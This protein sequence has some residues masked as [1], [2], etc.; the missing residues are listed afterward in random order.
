MT[1]HLMRA[2]VGATLTFVLAG[3]LCGTF[4]VRI[5]ALAD[6]LDISKTEVGLVLLVW[7]LGAL[8]TMQGMRPIM[9]R[10]GSRQVLRFAAPAC[11]IALIPLAFAPSLTLTL[12]AAALFGMAFGMVDIAMNAQGATVERAAARPAMNGMHAGWCVG[13]IAAGLLGTLA[14]QAGL[15]FTAHLTLIALLGVPASVLLS[16]TYLPDAPVRAEAGTARTGRLPRIVYLLGAI[17]FAAFMIEGTIADWNGIYLSEVLGAPEAVAALGYPIFEA[18]MLLGRLFGDRLRIRYGASALIGVGG[19]ATATAF[20]L[21]VAAPITAVALGGMLFVGLAISM[22]SPL[23]LSLAG[24]ADPA[25]SGPA[26]AQTGAMGYAGLLL[27][28]VVIGLLSDLATL[29]AALLIAVALGVGV[30]VAAR[31]IDRL[32]P[33]VVPMAEP[34]PRVRVEVAA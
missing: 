34:A 24:S 4:T 13:A 6:R 8:V 23:A 14:I 26:I 30:A 7:G 12:A 10:F 31:F 19:L 32:T 18:G 1:R 20:G 21:V 25:R 3:I 27:G 2:R 29:R 9:K 22:V 11:A 16:G 5:P 33:R 15:S 28:P 17:A